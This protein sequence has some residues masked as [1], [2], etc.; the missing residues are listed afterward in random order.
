VLFSA[1]LARTPAGR[2]ALEWRLE[3]AEEDDETCY[4]HTIQQ[5][6]PVNTHFCADQF[7][8]AY[9]P[10]IEEQYWHVAR[11]R[12]LAKHLR[13][14]PAKRVLDVG[15]G[16]GILVEYLLAMGMDAYGVELSPIAV[17]SGLEGR[18]FA[19][20]AA[21]SLTGSFRES[22][23]TLV[24]GDVIEHLPDPPSYLVNLLRAFE[25][26]TA[27][28][29][30]V[31]ARSEVW[32]NYDEYYGHYRRYDLAKLREAIT[33]IGFIPRELGYMFRFLYPPA[34]LL[35]ALGMQRPVSLTAPRRPAVDRMIAAAIE[36]EYF[37]CPRWIPGTSAICV[38]VREAGKG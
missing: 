25:R 8:D 29:I 38:A 4:P 27:I 5:K 12:I 15:C 36:A 13:A 37:L 11:N 33:A 6:D 17:P 21:E 30:T 7:S 24:L 35:R 9:P 34:L 10:G 18:L 28:V 3:R 31:P 16:R 2:Q 32:S 23:D 20:I 14:I 19:G 22:V 1:S 26:V